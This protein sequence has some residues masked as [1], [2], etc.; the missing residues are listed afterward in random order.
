MKF[1]VTYLPIFHHDIL[2]MTEALADYPIKAKRLFQEMD[3]KLLALEDI[4]YIWAVY[5]ANPKY[6]Q[7]I[8]EDHLLFYLVDEDERKI[9]AYRVLYDRMDVPKHIIMQL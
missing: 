2:K 3:R 8:L 5:H 7:M 9:R 4:P 1:K 6:R